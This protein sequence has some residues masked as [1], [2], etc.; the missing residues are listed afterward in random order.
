MTD[1]GATLASNFESK[2]NSKSKVQS[3]RLRLRSVKRHARSIGAPSR[4]SSFQLQRHW[5]GGSERVYAAEKA[6]IAAGLL[7]A[8]CGQRT[9]ALSAGQWAAR[10][11]NC[12]NS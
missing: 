7:A 5:A 8:L 12:G 4:L 11:H 3:P 1:F 2:S 6:T 9:G 10:T